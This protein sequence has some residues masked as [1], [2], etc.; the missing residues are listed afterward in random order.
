LEERY[1]GEGTKVEEVNNNKT[2]KDRR[3]SN[4]WRYSIK[5]YGHVDNGEL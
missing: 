5:E 2:K 3:L 4:Y 1:Q